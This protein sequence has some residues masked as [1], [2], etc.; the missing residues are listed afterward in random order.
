MY[1]SGRR[2]HPFRACGKSAGGKEKGSRKGKEGTR[3]RR[4]WV[5]GET[6]PKERWQVSRG[7]VRVC[8]EGD[9]G[10]SA[11]SRVGSTF[12]VPARNPRAPLLHVKKSSGL[13]KTRGGTSSWWRGS[14]SALIMQ[15]VGSAVKNTRDRTQ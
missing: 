7:W 8:A 15:S 5:G 13:V 3:R 4:V 1:F 12:G 14:G 10:R 9:G 2:G 6:A 11:T